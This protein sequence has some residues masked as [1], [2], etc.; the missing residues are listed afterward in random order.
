MDKEMKN[1]SEYILHDKTLMDKEMKKHSE[2]TLHI[3][4]I[5]KQNTIQ[6]KQNKK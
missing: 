1:Q 6:L 4:Q 5:N 2:Y 3:Q